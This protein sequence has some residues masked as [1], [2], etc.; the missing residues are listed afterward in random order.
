MEVL[1]LARN[2]S[3]ACTGLQINCLLK[4]LAWSIGLTIILTLIV[5]CILQFTRLSENLLPSFSSFIFFISMF[6]G[7]TIGTRS[8][9]CKGLLHGLSISIGYLILTIVLGT[10]ANP[11][12]LTLGIFLKRSTVTLTSGVLGGIIGIGLSNK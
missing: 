1:K 12:A 5:S 6:L 10:L 3:S 9:G 11:G 2:I 4:G 8:A 7:A